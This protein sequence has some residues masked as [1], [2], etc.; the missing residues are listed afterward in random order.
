MDLKQRAAEAPPARKG[1]VMTVMTRAGM[2][3]NAVGAIAYFTFI[4]ATFFLLVSPYK[5]SNYVRFHAWQ[6]ILLDIAAFLIEIVFGA[7]ALLTLFLGAI[8]FAYILRAISV[9]W[10]ILWLTCVIQAMNGRRFRI[11][12]LGNIA[13]KLA[14][15]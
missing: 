9:L 1:F 2:S 7:I 6:S 4:P 14:M 12:L 10:L 11:P 13:E 15:K 8:A 3:D 5:D